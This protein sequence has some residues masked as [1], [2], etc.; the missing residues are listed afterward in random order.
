MDE[1]KKMSSEEVELLL[2]P[3]EE[4]LMFNGARLGTVED[5]RL[6][7]SDM[8]VEGDR[9]VGDVPDDT[10]PSLARTETTAPF[11]RNGDGLVGKRVK[12]T[13]DPTNYSACQQSGSMAEEACSEQS[14]LS[15]KKGLKRR[16]S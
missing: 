6:L 15:K 7:D 3:D 4:D 12:T 11:N 9:R 14:N 5:E 13:S 8:E 16:W 2:C 10:Q 1:P